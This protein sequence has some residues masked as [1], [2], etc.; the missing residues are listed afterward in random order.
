MMRID[1]YLALPWSIERS[2]RDDDGHYY[3]LRVAELPGFVAAARD[4]DE[5]NETFWGALEAF[6][7][8]YLEEGKEPPMPAGYDRA[9][10]S[11]GDD[12]ELSGTTVYA[13]G[14]RTVSW[15]Q[16]TQV[17]SLDLAGAPA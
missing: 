11:P 2:E 4:L 17:T 10:T 15:P 6:L 3:V 12:A 16:V 14:P 1:E 8:S 9:D 13:D 5:L 7:G